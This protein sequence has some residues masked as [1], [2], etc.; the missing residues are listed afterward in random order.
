M[1]RIGLIINPIA[2]MGGRVGLKGTD[3]LAEKAR[4]LGARPQA[5]AKAVRALAALAQAPGL[6]LL[7]P[8]GDMGGRMAGSCGLTVQVLDMAGKAVTSGADTIK[9]ARMMA[10]MDA[11]LILFAGGDGTA[12]DICT[13]VG[14]GV[15]V[16]GIPAGVKI[17]SPV[18][19]QTPEAA[20]RL[21]LEVAKGNIRTFSPREVLDIDEEIYRQGR[22]QTRLYGYL[23]VPEAD[24]V[25][26]RKS[27]T[28][29]G[30]AAA[31]NLIALDYID[32]MEAEA[33]YLIGPGTTTRPV[34]ENLK[35]PNS[36]LGIDVVKNKQLVLNDSTE[37]DLLEITC[38]APDIRIFITPIGGQGYLFG[39]GNHQISP[40]II[41]RAG[42]E[43]IR[44]GATLQKIGSLRG[45]PFL[46][47]TGDPDT[48]RMLA[49]YTRVI[50]GYR[51][52][53]VYPI[54]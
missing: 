1:I 32:A 16:L 3:G 26:S 51:Q 35:L 27:G 38:N 33:V 23:S 47:D 39:R 13:A 18:F 14:E 22:V 10:S 21:A 45:R 50:T 48:D 52:E 8:P 40:E 11:D 4:E 54:G 6:T 28:P 25:Q 43:N 29:V 20:G 15:P 12:R 37:K 53:M 44:V 30:E 19:A 41:R 46:V 31:Q 17:H 49:G 2:G 9:A 42:K 5:A 36:L 34:M 7:S 24:R